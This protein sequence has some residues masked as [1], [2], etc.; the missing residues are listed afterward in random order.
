MDSQRVAMACILS[1]GEGRRLGGVCK[2]R[3]EVQQTP[4]VIRQLGVMHDSG[5]AHCV[6]MTGFQSGAIR[7]LVRSVASANESGGDGM[8]IECEDV[9]PA[10]SA[11]VA[12]ATDIQHSVR[13]ALRYARRILAVR[14][15]ISGVLISLV[16]LPLLSS[17]DVGSVLKHA[18]HFNV[19]VVVPVS[20]SGQS[21]HPVWL[22][23][24]FVNAMNLDVPAFSLRDELRLH[25]MAYAST[26]INMP[27]Q[28]LGPFIDVD[29]PQ[30]ILQVQ[31]DYGLTIA[32]P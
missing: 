29:T 9:P 11:R 23:R 3:L 1:A 17:D 6:V 18:A 8:V 19:S 5:I 13:A 15:E 10:T 20:A 27:T 25:R 30:D 32:M 16:D 14:P 22:S 7:S 12:A 31:A 26:V 2:G 28:S 4:L 21:G 24:S